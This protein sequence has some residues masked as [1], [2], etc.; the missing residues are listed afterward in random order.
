M[1]LQG[2]CLNITLG[3]SIGG[4]ENKSRKGVRISRERPEYVGKR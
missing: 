3:M 2:Q 4:G 1:L